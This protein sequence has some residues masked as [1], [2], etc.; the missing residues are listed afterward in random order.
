MVEQHT[1][2]VLRAPS[3]SR[4]TVIIFDEHYGKIEGLV[5]LEKHGSSLCHGALI[6][7]FPKK[8]GSK[9]ALENWNLLDMPMYWAQHDFLFFHHILELCDYFLQW[10][11]PSPEVFRLVHILY[12]NP[13]ALEERTAQKS[14]LYYLFK[15]FGMYPDLQ[16]STLG[17]WFRACINTHP[18]AESLNTVAFLTVLDRY[19]DLS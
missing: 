10:D 6:S 3:P 7:Y 4:N 17:K 12:T 14:F 15:S 11:E 19:E 2:I 5:F 18:R 1:G 8:K 13:L 16:S 9:Y